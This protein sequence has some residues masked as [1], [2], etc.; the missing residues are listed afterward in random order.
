MSW[1]FGCINKAKRKHSK[2]R[3]CTC[4]VKV[5]LEAGAQQKAADAHL[6]EAIQGY[7]VSGCNH[8]YVYVG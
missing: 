3:L 7:D 4:Q 1:R 8:V 6:E 2:A 5:L